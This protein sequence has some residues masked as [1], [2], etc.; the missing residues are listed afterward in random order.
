MPRVGIGNL[1]K[2]LAVV[3]LAI[4]TTSA[5]PAFAATPG[6]RVSPAP[7]TEAS[8]APSEAVPTPYP[9]PTA[10]PSPSDESAEGAK[11]P[12]IDTGDENGA[13]EGQPARQM[14]GAAAIEVAD[15][16]FRPMQLT[17]TVGTKVVWTVV[18]QN[19]HTV[20]ADDRSF[21][22][23]TLEGGRTFS[24][25]FDEVG[26]VPYYCQI[27]GEPGSGMFGIVL[28]QAAPADAGDQATPAPGSDDLPRTGLDP[29]PLVLATLGLAMAGLLSLRVGRNATG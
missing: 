8:P 25:T 22:S 26:R 21:D 13:G 2:G 16:E 24:V 5:I 28:V 9:G 23:S 14:R 10:R 17:V 27:H 4:Q 20:T 29:I 18:G 1:Q 7:S 12:L 6:E 15:N 19:P 11:E 3:A